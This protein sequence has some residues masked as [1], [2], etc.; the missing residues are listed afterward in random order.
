MNMSTQ[1]KC[2]RAPHR[3]I[4]A[5]VLGALVA[6]GV[7]LMPA[8][9]FAASQD[10]DYGN[11]LLNPSKSVLLA[12]RRGRVTIYDGLEHD[13]VERAMD[14]QFDRIGSMMFVR[15]REVG[16]DKTEESDDDC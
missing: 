3:T 12:E 7:A 5:V 14:T 16:P 2:S 13:E 11:A 10:D 15:T 4:L 1:T 8:M 9:S 6:G